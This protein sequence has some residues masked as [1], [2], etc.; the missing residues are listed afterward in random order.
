M[1]HKITSHPKINESTVKQWHGI[2][3]LLAETLQVPVALIMH[4][5]NDRLSVQVKNE[6]QNNPYQ[7][8]SSEN[9]SG[10]GLYCE[11]VIRTNNLL[12]VPNALEDEKWK[13]NPDVRLNMINYLGYPLTWP[14]GDVYGTICVLD[15]HTHHYSDIQHRIMLHLK[16]TIDASLEML[17]QSE[18]LRF[19]SNILNNVAQ[20]IYIVRSRDGEIAFANRQFESMF[21]YESG[22]LTG[23]HVSIVN[24]YSEVDPIEIAR[25]IIAEL[26]KT[27]LWHGEVHN[28]RKDGTTFWCY[29][30]V[31][32]LEHPEFG[33]V[34]V[35]THE[36]I[37][38][39]KKAEEELRLM[40][41]SID[42][43]PDAVYRMTPDGQFL[44]VNKMACQTLG[45]SVEE[46][47]TMGVADIDP[48]VPF[49]VSPELAQA[50]K[51][52]KTAQIESE[53]RTKDGR[54][55]PVE[56][57]V[58]HLEYDGKEYHC[59]FV[60]DITDRKK[61]EASLRL[62]ASVFDISQEAIII[63]DAD[64]MIVDVNSAFSHITGYSR[65]EVIGKNPKLLNSGRQGK[66]YYAAM[67]KTIIQHKS[68]RGEVWNRRKSGEIY[69][70]MLSIS[71][72]C[73][74]DGK[75]M[76]YVAVFSDIT[77]VKEHEAE[78]SHVAHHDGLT[79][80]PNRILL[81]DRMRQAIAET[82][83]NH[84]MMAICYLD[85][86]GFKPVNDNLG[87]EA[88]DNVL[89]EI[90]KRIE[91]TIRGG[92][93]V[94]RL[95]GDEFV[96]LLL[97]LK[98]G[99]ECVATLDR[100]LE[101]I[102]QP[103]TVKTKPVNVN[104][105]ASIGV[106]LYPFDEEDPDTLLRHADQAMYVAKQMGKNRFHIFD[107]QMD[108][109]ARK[110]NEFLKSIRSALEQNQFELFYQPKVNLLMN[111]LI[112]VEALIRWRHPERG[113]LPPA[114]FLHIIENTDLDIGIGEWVI[115]TAL[116][117]MK[118]W[119]SVGLDIEVSI[120]ISGYHLESVGFIE[121]L[122]QHLNQYTDMAP[123]KL[124][125]EVLE[126]VALKDITI[127]QGIIEVGR[128]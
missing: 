86:D 97:G 113:I 46:M 41:F 64:N 110:Q 52:A 105:S 23:K 120:N 16:K 32:T 37:T 54:I 112:G 65:E 36:D 69:P 50:T 66:A 48:N 104:V 103:I 100:L 81:A 95:G 75:V 43:A 128:Q 60:R 71:A 89:V 63:S 101:V 96:V 11:T 17:E 78:L 5:E 88:G 6:S 106:S 35:S 58:N 13:A 102:A 30:T 91:Q 44:Y 33:Q 126:T 84:E 53:H 57:L 70:E 114:E 39:R 7:L 123:G 74:D 34:W 20:G 107:P 68:W 45:Y 59:S 98:H 28:T 22:E 3:N 118:C 121:K 109:R 93:T 85:L 99:E 87:H 31:S 55:I 38:E 73:D 115:A 49:G 4:L 10:S 92:D 51:I 40:K 127:V 47:L 80:I 21:G 27:G 122:K 14:N 29:V 67:W 124:Q 12:F 62:T 1:L 83:R 15:T 77:K 108:R 119:R 24:A 18:I 9:F 25:T 2:V 26:D 117:Q 111:K 72:V 116:A 76:R 8:G 56:I 19:H 94:A 42:H 90:A 61:S 125:I 79:G 82:S